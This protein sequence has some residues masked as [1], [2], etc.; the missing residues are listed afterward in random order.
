MAD[1]ICRTFLIVVLL[2][3]L[4]LLGLLVHW[5]VRTWLPKPGKTSD[6]QR[7]HGISPTPLV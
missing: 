7:S 4:V 2:D 6:A 3:Y 5:T 1:T